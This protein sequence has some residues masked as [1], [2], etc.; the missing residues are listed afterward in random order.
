MEQL[1]RARFQEDVAA[2]ALQIELAHALGT[3]RAAVDFPIGGGNTGTVS[4]AEVAKATRDAEHL[5]KQQGVLE[6]L[7]PALRTVSGD[8]GAVAKAITPA[9]LPLAIGPQAILS[10]TPLAFGALAVVV[11]RAGVRALCPQGS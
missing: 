3:G 8:L 1:D 6:R 10:L 4:A 5:I 7:C 2:A 9:L 11:V